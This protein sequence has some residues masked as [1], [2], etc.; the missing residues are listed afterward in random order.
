M[1]IATK[2]NALNIARFLAA[3][4]LVVMIEGRGTYYL[5]T[6]GVTG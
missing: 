2:N 1:K 6:W 5:L 3:S 4:G